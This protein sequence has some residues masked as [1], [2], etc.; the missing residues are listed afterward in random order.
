[1]V[2][3]LVFV[4]LLAF[5]LSASAKE[6]MFLLDKLPA[7]DLK[8]S[9]LKIPVAKLGELSRAVVQVARGGSG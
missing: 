7:K 9:G 1:M 4:T 8:R 2:R 5:P 6:G 3:L